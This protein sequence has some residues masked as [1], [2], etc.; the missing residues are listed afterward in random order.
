MG[1]LRSLEDHL[2]NCG[3]IL[4]PCP[5][6][7][8]HIT[9][10]ESEI[11]VLYSKDIQK[12][13]EEECPRRSYSCPYCEEVGEYEHIT[14][15]HYHECPKVEIECSNVPDCDKRF[16]R[17]SKS[18]HISVCPFE[19]VPCRYKAVGCEEWL[20]RKELKQH[21]NNNDAHLHLS[22]KMIVSLNTEIV[23][24][25]TELQE[26]LEFNDVLVTF[27]E[28]KN[29]QLEKQCSDLESA[30]QDLQYQMSQLSTSKSQARLTFK[31]PHFSEYKRS[32][33]TFHGPTFL[34]HPHGYK[35]IICIDANGYSQYKGT[36]ISV[37]MYLMRGDYD[38]DLQFPLSG[39]FT[40]ELLNQLRDSNH[41]KRSCVR[42]GTESYNRVLDQEMAENG[43]GVA[44]FISHSELGF[45]AFEN[46]Q[47]LKDDCLVFRIYTE[48]TSYK[49]WLQCTTT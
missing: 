20:L 43:F 42:V 9:E 19:K 40:F 34:T 5:N 17:E 11:V 37:W 23:H 32:D 26:A 33:K 2:E 27:L 39:T 47:Y 10:D 21:E 4:Q 35:M 14:T 12:H 38:D 31:I 46:C 41:H 7:C 3:F 36:H 28:T 49:P 29:D 24:L 48:M 22:M 45:N 16:L 6:W 44:G 13:L 1:E 8:S 25:K 15:D 30:N 18:D